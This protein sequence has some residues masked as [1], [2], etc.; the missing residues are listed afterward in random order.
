MLNLHRIMKQQLF[1]YLLCVTALFTLGMDFDDRD[2]NYS[3]TQPSIDSD[4]II[5]IMNNVG[6][7]QEEQDRIETTAK[8]HDKSFTNTKEMT[9]NYKVTSYY[10]NVRE[11]SNVISKILSVVKNGDILEVLQTTDNNWLELKSG[12]YVNSKYTE[13]ISTYVTATKVS[14]LPLNNMK[15]TAPSKPTS[16][17]KSDSRLT[18]ENIVKIFE[19]T[20]LA[21]HELEKT[22]LEIEKDYGINAYFTIAVMKLE[23]GHGKSKLA[24]E[25]NNLFGLN[26]I[27]GDAFNKAFSF[28]TK[29]ES[30]QKFGQLISE[31]Y[32]D[33]GYTSVEKV[34]S[35]YC[36]ANPKWSTLVMKIMKN[37]YK[38]LL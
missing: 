2:I 9:A 32:V 10:L 12:G 17:V 5:P 36:K 33:K 35:K 37:D 24:K 38:K 4:I 27:D 11:N 3:D 13:L 7:A 19:G 16:T 31:N 15:A 8:Q 14:Q 25:K 23:S 6:K 18:E 20:S 1:V 34:A 28:K 30:V 22:I 26:A 29:G 21:D